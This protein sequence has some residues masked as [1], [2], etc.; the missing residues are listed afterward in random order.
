MM[1]TVGVAAGALADLPRPS[2]G[3]SG[4]RRRAIAERNRQ[5]PFR[6][7]LREIW[8]EP[9][10]AMF[11]IFVF[12][13]MTAYF[14]QELILE[15]YSPASS[16]ASRRGSPRAVRR[17][18]WGVFLGMVLVVGIAGTGCWIGSL[19]SGSSRAASARPARWRPSRPW[20]SSSRAGR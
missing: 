3:S 15:P 13:S 6:E 11:T 14:M 7:G 12:L 9:G 20:A 2:G 5:P 8:A 17:A 18:E 4:Q 1:V 19:R 10:R 16:S